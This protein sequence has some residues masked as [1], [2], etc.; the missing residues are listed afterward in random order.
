MTAA[1][2][3][4]GEEAA[5]VIPALAD[6]FAPSADGEPPVDLDAWARA[7]AADPPRTLAAILGSEDAVVEAFLDAFDAIELPP[8]DPRARAFAEEVPSW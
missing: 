5:E 8:N 4:A 1:P 7:W 6:F 3:D 2:E